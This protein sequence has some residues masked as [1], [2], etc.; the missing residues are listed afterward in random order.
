[1]GSDFCSELGMKSRSQETKKYIHEEME[2]MGISYS[3]KVLT[4]TSHNFVVT[5]GWV[6]SLFTTRDS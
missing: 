5:E 6:G 1:M 3:F 2:L 4:E